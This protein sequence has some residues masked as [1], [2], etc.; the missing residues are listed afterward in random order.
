MEEFDVL[1]KLPRVA[2]P[3]DF[4][5]RVMARLAERKRGRT[6]VAHLRPRL[7]LAAAPAALLAAFLLV[8]I[9]ILRRPGSP[10]GTESG[11]AFS[12]ATVRSEDT[13]R[14]TEPL[15]YRQDIRSF[16]EESGTMYILESVSDEAPH[17]IFY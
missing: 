14:L 2:A 17:G 6:S 5:E 9:F 10:P 15:D 13:I 11:G 1:K 16:S 8:N 3:P 12:Y 7:W 4:E